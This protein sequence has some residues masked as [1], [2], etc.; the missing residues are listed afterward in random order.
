MYEKLNAD[1]L[2]PIAASAPELPAPAPH[3]KRSVKKLTPTPYDSMPQQPAADLQPAPAPIKKRSVKKF[4]PSDLQPAPAPIKK[5]SVKKL[6]PSADA[7]LPAPAPRKKR[8]DKKLPYVGTYV[9][10]PEPPRTIP[11]GGYGVVPLKPKNQ[12]EA[13]TDPFNF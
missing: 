8:S 13:A 2:L 3:K 4:T 10:T 7:E 12:Y 1:M 6:T 9:A 11:K 5:R